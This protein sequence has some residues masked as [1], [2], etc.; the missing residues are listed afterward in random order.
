MKFLPPLKQ[1]TLIQRYKRFLAD[2]KL[3]CGKEKT[4]HCANTGAMTGCGSNGDIIWYS[5]SSNPK[6]KYPNSWEITQ[7][8]EGHKICVNTARA[9]QLVIEAIKSN[10]VKELLGY[11]EIQ[12]EVNYG[13]ENSRI[14]ILLKSENEPNC[15]IE[16]KSVTLLSEDGQGYFPDSV[17][18]RGQKHLREL[19][20]MAQ[21]GSRA[22]LFFTVL[23][24]G[25]EKVAPA[26]HIDAKYSQLLNYAIEHG[27]EVL[28]YK[29][30]YSTNEIEL[31][32]PIKFNAAQ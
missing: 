16:V 26:H 19:T 13:I 18:T 24:S 17:T 27:V 11:Q 12:T 3:P 2:I 15:Y 14:D 10:R 32:R 4:I 5:T 28:C 7:S 20:E 30:E 21:S 22:V 9:N 1:A 25:I 8:S 31:V 6:R 23:H 29:A